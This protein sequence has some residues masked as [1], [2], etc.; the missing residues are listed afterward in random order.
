MRWTTTPSPTAA[1]AAVVLLTLAVPDR[2]FAQQPA[3]SPQASPSAAI[4]PP[5]GED[6]DAGQV[7]DRLRQVL[8][9]YPPSLRRVLQ[10]DPSLLSNQ[11]YLATYPTLARFVATHPQVA[12][13]PA[14]FVGT[15][16]WEEPQRPS[17]DAVRIFERFSEGATIVLVFS[18]I[19]SALIWLTKTLI[20][21]RRWARLSKVQAEVHSKLLDRFSAS[22]ELLAYI[23]TPAGSRFLES[24]PIPLEAAPAR[25]GAPLGRILWSVQIGLVLVCAGVGFTFLSGRT[26]PEVASL[27]WVVG[28]LALSLGAGFVLSAGVSWLLSRRL[29]L[30]ER[31]EPAE[32]TSAPGTLG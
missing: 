8:D 32:T 21:Y 4:Q 15:P 31:A 18:V 3:P 27:L 13:N 17:S 20:D 26:L 7:R 2:A 12:H 10:F 5:V 16:D 11:E 23:R 28:V 30:L 6:V 22:D 9:Q 19:A 14:F 1:L 29:G 24:A 25:M